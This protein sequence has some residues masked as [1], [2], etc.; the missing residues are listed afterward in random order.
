MAVTTTLTGGWQVV[1]SPKYYEEWQ[2]SYATT[3]TTANASGIFGANSA[4]TI[5][6]NPNT[7]EFRALSSEDIYSQVVGRVGVRAR[8]SFGLVNTGTAYMNYAIKRNLNATGDIS[9]SINVVWS[10]RI[11]QS[12]STFATTYFIL[13]G[14]RP[15][16]Y[17]VTGRAGALLQGETELIAKSFDFT[18]VGSTYFF[19]TI[20]S[21]PTDAVWNFED[22]G[23]NPVTLFGRV[24]DCTDFNWGVERDLKEV[25]VL[26]ASTVAF[27]PPGNRSITGDFTAVFLSVSTITQDLLTQTSGTISWVM[28]TGAGTPTFSSATLINHSLPVEIANET[29][30]RVSFRANLM[31]TM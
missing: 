14:A 19:S 15:N 16:S 1:D 5:E 26:G 3:I 20:A 23:A 17:R 9:R 29:Y 18:T 28:K 10:Q 13:Y 7:N 21:D 4:I 24:V 25:F 30:E 12:G 2:T 8:I 11:F 22:G 27:L 31:S 6:I